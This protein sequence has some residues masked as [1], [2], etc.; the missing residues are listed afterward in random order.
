M[1]DD[2]DDEA[3]Q[4]EP[5]ETDTIGVEKLETIDIDF[6]ITLSPTYA[7]PVLWFTSP[8][9]ASVDRIYNLL[10]ADHLIEPARSIGVM[11][12]ISQAVNQHLLLRSFQLTCIVVPSYYR[13]SGL[14]RSSLQY[15]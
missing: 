3:L 6:S 11:G 7:V 14:L 2:H 8:A 15:T 5:H 10:T 13:T 4:L 9:L 12:G 1:E